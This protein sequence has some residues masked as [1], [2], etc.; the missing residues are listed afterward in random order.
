MFFISV[1]MYG[2]GPQGTSGLECELTY[3]HYNLSVRILILT[4]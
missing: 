4:L 3:D 2:K 1:K